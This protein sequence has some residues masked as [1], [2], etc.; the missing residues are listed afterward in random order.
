MTLIDEKAQARDAAKARRAAAARPDAGERLAARLLEAVPLEAGAVVSGFW[1]MGDELDICP[2]L[3]QLAAAGHPLALPV[4]VKRG[5]PLIFRRWRPGEALVPASFGTSV[6][7]P[8]AEVLEPSVLLVPL[9]AFDRDGYRLGYGGGFY[10]RTLTKLRAAR[11]TTAVGVAYAGQ[12]VPAVPRG[13]HDARLD[14]I[15]T[16]RE[17]IV[18]VRASARRAAGR[19]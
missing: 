3:E 2:A 10:D 5:E 11:P 12:E 6:P 4:V 8:E 1:P 13:P 17:A 18:V 16:E 7:A 14:W 15:V 9:L 19:E